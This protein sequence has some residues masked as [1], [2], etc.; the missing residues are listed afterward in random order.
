MLL[1]SSIAFRS[2]LW[3]IQQRVLSTT[4]HRNIASQPTSIDRKRVQ[5]GWNEREWN[6]E[7]YI[8]TEFSNCLVKINEIE[9][10][11]AQRMHR[12]FE[13]K[14]VLTTRPHRAWTVMYITPLKFDWR[15]FSS[16][17][18]NIITTVT[19]EN[20]KVLPSQ[21]LSLSSSSSTF[22]LL[23]LSTA[24]G[25][26]WTFFTQCGSETNAISQQAQRLY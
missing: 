26:R 4:R 9:A 5:N 17:R 16:R 18:L 19:T 24:G 3:C 10:I 23:P 25:I 13:K 6:H 11:K 20:M 1:P 2:V 14:N 8:A 7:H 22:R 15:F 21:V 12:N